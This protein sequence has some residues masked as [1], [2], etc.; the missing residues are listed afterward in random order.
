M[1]N[2]ILSHE[3]LKRFRQILIG[4][5]TSQCLN[6]YME[7]CLNFST[8]GTKMRKKLRMTLDWT[9]GWGVS[10]GGGVGVCE[11]AILDWAVTDGRVEQPLFL[12]PSLYS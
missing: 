11:G 4:L 5:I 6:K 12:L 8:K 9:R 1:E 3:G 10:V 7:L 2:P